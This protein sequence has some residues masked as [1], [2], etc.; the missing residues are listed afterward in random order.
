MRKPRSQKRDVCPRK[1]RESSCLSLRATRLAAAY[2]LRR[3]CHR[4]RGPVALPRSGCP[5]RRSR[6]PAALWCGR[7]LPLRFHSGPSSSKVCATRTSSTVPL[8][9]FAPRGGP[10]RFAAARRRA[11]GSACKTRPGKFPRTPL[12]ARAK[13]AAAAIRRRGSLPKANRC[14]T[15]KPLIKAAGVRNPRCPLR[16]HRTCGPSKPVR[17]GVAPRSA[18]LR[19]PR[20]SAV[21]FILLRYVLASV[22]RALT[23]FRARP[24]SQ[25][26]SHTQGALVVTRHRPQH[27]LYFFPLPHGQGS[28][29]PTFSPASRSACISA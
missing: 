14:S 5:V 2:R 22:E 29:R 6:H 8:G 13:P 4:P 11:R 28:L 9:P 3:S 25:L 15:C 12:S 16:V 19:R 7:C 24:R 17:T 1:L 20:G 23:T 27:R 26:H 18:V 21:V 10:V